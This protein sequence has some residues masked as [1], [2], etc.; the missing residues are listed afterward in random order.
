[1]LNWICNMIVT[2]LLFFPEESFIAQPQDL[3]LESEAVT[4]VTSDGIKLFGWYLPAKNPKGTLLLLHGNAGNISG[5]LDKVKGWV[6]R[7]VS[8]FLIDYR[9][10]GKSEGVITCETDL[11]LDGAAALK[12]LKDT[13]GIPYSEI[14]VYGESL[15]AAPA[16]ELAVQTRLKGL[17]LEVPFTSLREIAKAHYPWAPGFFLRNFQLDNLAKIGKIPCP[18]FIIHGTEDDV[19]PYE[20]GRRLFEAASQPKDF[21]SVPGGFHSDLPEKA[22]PDYFEKPYRFF[23]GD[24]R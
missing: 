2:T 13:K 24:K 5:R 23:V 15:G 14:I 3:G 17:L 4:C 7:G 18:V 9:G 22:G 10:Y 20:M 16:T 19:C 11:Y 1:M 6:D 21:L 8:V 12:W